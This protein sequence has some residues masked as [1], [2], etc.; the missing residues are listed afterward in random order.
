MALSLVGVTMAMAAAATYG[1]FD[2]RRHGVSRDDDDE[3]G[4]GFLCGEKLRGLWR[5][6]RYVGTCGKIR[7]RYLTYRLAEKDC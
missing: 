5:G 4:G 2:V 3:D 1:S 7:E 6:K